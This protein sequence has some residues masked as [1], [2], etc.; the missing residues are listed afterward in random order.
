MTQERLIRLTEV[1]SK[2]GLARSTVWYFVKMKRLP[3]PIKLS[4]RVTVWKES[5]IM[6]FIVNAGIFNN[7]MGEDDVKESRS[8]KI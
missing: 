1:M 5:E 8:R 3:K 2:T 6:Q 7:T 4:K